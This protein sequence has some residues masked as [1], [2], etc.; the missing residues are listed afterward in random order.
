LLSSHTLSPTLNSTLSWC[1]SAYFLYFSELFP[2]SSGIVHPCHGFGV[3]VQ[4]VQGLNQR[5]HNQCIPDDN[6][7]L[8]RT[9]TCQLTGGSGCCMWIQLC[10]GM[11][12]NHP[13]D[14]PRT[15]EGGSQAI[16]CLTQ[17]GLGFQDDMLWRI[18]GWYLDSS[19]V[20]IC[21][22]LWT[23]VH[24]QC[25]DT[26]EAHARARHDGCVIWPIVLRYR[27]IYR[28]WSGPFWSSNLYH[29]DHVMPFW[30]WQLCDKVWLG[31]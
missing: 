29:V 18:I 4:G 3:S 28:D 27:W 8:H 31:P 22:G 24:D 11:L 6:N 16:Y 13:V 20:H 19:I 10:E 12:P 15:C 14:M 21:K 17:L 5:S 7:S 1:Q 25:C 23:V 30:R 9:V 2:R 26:M